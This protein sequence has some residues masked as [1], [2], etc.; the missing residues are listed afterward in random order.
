MVAP[1]PGR[2]RPARADDLPALQVVEV[3]AGRLFADVGLQSVAD[4]PPLPLHALAGFQHDGRAW[5]S[6]DDEDRP[7]GYALALEVDG[8]G[9]L[10][11]LSVTPA[12]GR[13]G[14]GRA[15]VEVVVAWARERGAPALTLSTFR[16]VPWN[17]PWYARAGFRPLAE[18]ELTPA[19]V[20]LRANEVAAGLDVSRRVLMRREL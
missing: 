1:P 13:Q 18:G 5:V 19:L 10:E 14:R 6:V 15:L 4:D 11:Q 3:E 17:A 7:V 16:D 8:L 20:Q 12:A 2:I 9:H